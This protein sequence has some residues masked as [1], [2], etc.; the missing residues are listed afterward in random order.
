M[1]SPQHK[2]RTHTNTEINY[3]AKVAVPVARLVSPAFERTENRRLQ[4]AIRSQ[5]FWAVWVHPCC[6]RL[7]DRL[8]RPSAYVS[9][10][11]QTMDECFVFPSVVQVSE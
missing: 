2:I 5:S 4:Q 7:V 3:Q 10:L 9:I 11:P 8:V 1:Y 6:P